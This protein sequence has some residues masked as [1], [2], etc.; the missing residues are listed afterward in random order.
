MSCRRR[1]CRGPWPW[2]SQHLRANREPV[3][4]TN[5]PSWNSAISAFWLIAMRAFAGCR[6][7]PRR[8]T[9]ANDRYRASV[10]QDQRTYI[11]DVHAL[12]ELRSCCRSGA[13]AAIAQQGQLACGSAEHRRGHVHPGVAPHRGGGLDTLM[14]AAHQ[15]HAP[16]TVSSLRRPR[17][18]VTEG[19]ARKRRRY[20]R[21]CRRASASDGAGVW[22]MPLSRDRRLV[23]GAA[24]RASGA[25]TLLSR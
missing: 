3:F 7:H 20:V 19:T 5:P 17:R 23:V 9:L 10:D 11:A 15:A 12:A 18:T 6:S 22:V 4:C 13:P 1:G 21:S 24:R 25:E 2:L 14:Y 16:T 8:A